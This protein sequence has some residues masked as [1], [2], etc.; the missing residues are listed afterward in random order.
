MR[1][2]LPGCCLLFIP[3]LLCGEERHELRAIARA[4]QCTAYLC[5]L[6]SNE[7]IVRFYRLKPAVRDPSFVQQDTSDHVLQPLWGVSRP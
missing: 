3:C 2:G 5:R 6:E 7:S 1:P 4:R